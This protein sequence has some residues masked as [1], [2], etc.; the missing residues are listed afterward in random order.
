MGAA[1]EP[2]DAGVDPLGKR[3][4]EVGCGGGYYLSRFLDYGAARA[5]GIDLME[6][7][8]AVRGNAIRGSSSSRATRRGCRGTR[9]RS[10]S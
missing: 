4:L 5:T 7:R 1:G 10:T 8:V 2:R 3:V 9:A 6:Q